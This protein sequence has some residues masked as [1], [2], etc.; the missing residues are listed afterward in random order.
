MIVWQ[1]VA[2]LL[3]GTCIEFLAECHDI[4][5]ALTQ[6]RAN[7]GRRIRLACRDLELDKSDYF[8]ATEAS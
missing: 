1:V 4:D 5:T 8:L 6:C 2:S 3:L 7:W